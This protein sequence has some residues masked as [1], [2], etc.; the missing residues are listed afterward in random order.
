LRGERSTNREVNPMFNFIKGF[1]F[2]VLTAAVVLVGF[3]YTHHVVR[4]TDGLHVVN[5]TPY[6]FDKIYVDM[7][8]WSALDAVR[9]RDVLLAMGQSGLERAKDS[10]QQT[11][12]QTRDSA[13]KSLDDAKR[14]LDKL[15]EKR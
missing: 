1:V 5:K 3:A 15:F 12:S 6:S 7:T 14:E 2:G 13:Q 9:N 4:A 11:L 8:S 10:A